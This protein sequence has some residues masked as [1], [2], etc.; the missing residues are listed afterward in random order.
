MNP[1]LRNQI[2]I[3]AV[4][5]LVVAGLIFLFLGG[6]R[7]ELSAAEAANKL[8]SAEVDKGNLLKANAKKLEE[9]IKIQKAR[10]NELVRMMPTDADRGDIPYRIKKLAD[11]A[12]IEVTLFSSEVAAAGAP[13]MSNAYYN[14]YPVKFKFLAGYHTFGQFTSLLSGFEKIIGLNEMSMV[15]NSAARAIYPVIIECKISAYVY[16]PDPPPEAAAPAAPRPAAA[17]KAGAGADKD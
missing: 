8:L 1:Q 2:L 6:K 10:I 17:P 4:A 14:R 5:G 3:G 11:A 12:G 15:K 9:E 13:D 16:K 7:D